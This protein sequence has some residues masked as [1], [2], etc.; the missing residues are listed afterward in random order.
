MIYFYFQSQKS[1]KVQYLP[2]PKSKSYE[3]YIH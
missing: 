2:H 3:T 1:F